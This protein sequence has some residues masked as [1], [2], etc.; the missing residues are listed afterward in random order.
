MNTSKDALSEAILLLA[1]RGITLL[2]RFIAIQ[3]HARGGRYYPAAFGGERPAAD[4]RYHRYDNGRFGHFDLKLT[5]IYPFRSRIRWSLHSVLPPS[6]CEPLLY[7][8]QHHR[9]RAG[10]LCR[11]SVHNSQRIR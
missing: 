3:S 1:L 7:P 9:L 6:L 10:K 2:L 11:W 4:G 5:I 8:Y